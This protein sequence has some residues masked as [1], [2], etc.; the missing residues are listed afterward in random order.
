MR[1]S[2]K[3]LSV[4]MLT[5]LVACSPAPQPMT[6]P[7]ENLAPSCVGSAP[8]EIEGTTLVENDSLLNAVIGEVGKGMLC[9]GRVFQVDSTIQ[10]Y[11]VYTKAKSYTALGSW[12]SFNQPVGPREEYARA[13]DICPEW[14]ALD[15]VHHCTIK[16]GTQIVVGP[17]QSAQCEQELLPASA[18]IQV[19]VY[20][21]TR[22]DIVQVEDCSEPQPW[23]KN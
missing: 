22:K 4:A 17:G 13:N 11:R 2:I 15:I 6:E 7:Q 3:I 1:I 10:V 14:S 20:N 5:L 23:P 9:E 19:Y 16:P 21:D 18:N 8:S 12:W